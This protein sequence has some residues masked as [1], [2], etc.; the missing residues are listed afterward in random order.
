MAS[1]NFVTPDKCP[2][3][4]PLDRG[5]RTD[6]NE[7]YWGLFSS[8]L[9]N[10]GIYQV[11]MFGK[12][13]QLILNPDINS[14]RNAYIRSFQCDIHKRRKQVSLHSFILSHLSQFLVNFGK[15]DILIA[16]IWHSTSIR[17]FVNFDLFL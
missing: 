8:Q 10:Y 13:I 15:C 3:C 9:V 2:G 17:F 1:L 11:T 7:A 16:E 14:T 4:L 5:L 6:P 12:N